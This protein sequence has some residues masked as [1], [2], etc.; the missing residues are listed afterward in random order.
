MKQ[1]YKIGGMTCVACSSGLER[2]LKK[3]DGVV[4]VEVSF[5]TETMDIEYNNNITFEEIENTVKSL[6]FYIVND[7]E[8]EKKKVN[9]I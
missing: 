2:L 7:E 4:S 6:G 5:A 3:K 9:L 8:K 1:T